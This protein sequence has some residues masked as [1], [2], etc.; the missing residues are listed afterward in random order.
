MQNSMREEKGSSGTTGQREGL[1]ESIALYMLRC[2]KMSVCLGL[3]MTADKCTGCN[4]FSCR[5]L[6]LHHCVWIATNV[7][8][9]II[10]RVGF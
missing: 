5:L 2:F 10:S 8:V 7:F 6:V 1:L 4:N 3:L 9:A